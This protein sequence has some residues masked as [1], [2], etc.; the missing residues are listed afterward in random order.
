[1]V[2]RELQPEKLQVYV[3]G[4]CDFIYIVVRLVHPQK[5]FPDPPDREVTELGMVMQVS[6]VQL[7]KASPIICVTEVGICIEVMFSW[8]AKAPLPIQVTV[9]GMT[10]ALPPAISVLVEVFM[11][12]LQ[13]FLES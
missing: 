4:V 9:L 6:P 1:M 8:P 10:E 5:T 13:L 3:G 7:P 2:V 11:I 12:A